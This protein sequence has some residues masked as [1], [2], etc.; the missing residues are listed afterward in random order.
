MKT[1]KNKK[2]KD[3]SDAGYDQGYIYAL[4]GGNTCEF[5]RYDV[6]AQSPGPNLT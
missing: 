4:K 3:G 1:G 6:G 5:Y 2:A